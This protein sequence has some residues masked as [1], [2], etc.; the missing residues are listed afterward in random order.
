MLILSDGTESIR[1]WYCLCFCLHNK[2]LSFSWYLCVCVW[3]L[4]FFSEN[5]FGIWILFLFSECFFR[6]GSIGSTQNALKK[7]TL[8]KIAV[9][10]EV[11]LC[12]MLLLLF[13]HCYWY[14]KGKTFEC[15]YDFSY[16]ARVNWKMEEKY[17]NLC[18]DFFHLKVCIWEFAR[19]LKHFFYLVPLYPFIWW[20]IVIRIEI[21]GKK[22]CHRIRIVFGGW[23][24]GQKWKVVE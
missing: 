16:L 8:L 14:V 18:V 6:S 21:T 4:C 11:K 1:W 13:L 19:H 22:R 12:H 23:K 17:E 10:V 9:Q 5:F 3:I 7:A 20:K 24:M 15:K 2:L